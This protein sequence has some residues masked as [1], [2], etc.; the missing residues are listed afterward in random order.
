VESVVCWGVF[1]VFCFLLQLKVCDY[2]AEFSS[3]EVKNEL[4]LL[5]WCLFPRITDVYISMAAK[6]G[7]KKLAL[8]KEAILS[9]GIILG[10]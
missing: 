2:A 4:Y 9:V 7:N 5:A 8:F 10:L 1:V 3:N 6:C